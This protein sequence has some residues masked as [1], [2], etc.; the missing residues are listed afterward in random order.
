[1]LHAILFHSVFGVIIWYALRLVASHFKSMKRPLKPCTETFTQS[2]GLPYAYVC[3]TKKQLG[4][5]VTN[6][7]NEH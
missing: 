4:G 2:M 1:M 5:V 7:F 6:D 3:N